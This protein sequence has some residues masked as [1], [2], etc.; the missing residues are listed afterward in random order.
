[1]PPF[2]HMLN[3]SREITPS[4]PS[5]EKRFTIAVPTRFTP[6]MTPAGILGF[7]GSAKGGTKIRVHSGDVWCWL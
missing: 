1:M 7:T 6:V 2:H 3:V 4:F 5:C